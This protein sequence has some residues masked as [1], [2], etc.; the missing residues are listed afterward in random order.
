MSTFA[1]FGMSRRYAL[2]AARK[3]VPQAKGGEV[4]PESEWL[5]QVDD[6]ADEI[7]SSKR[8]VQLS[9][10]FDTPHVA[11]EF[12]NIAKGAGCRDLRIKAYIVTDKRS[13]KTGK[14]KK[15]WISIDPETLQPSDGN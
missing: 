9:E 1:V 3:S 10:K 2:E 13:L 5:S 15:K 7:M 6:A 12:L 4:L 14:L 8:V 11:K